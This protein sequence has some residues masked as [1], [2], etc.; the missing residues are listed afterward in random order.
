M[1]CFLIDPGGWVEVDDQA[2]APG[3]FCWNSEVGRR[4]LGVQT[5]WFQA[6]C[7][8][9]LVWDPIEVVEFSRKHTANIGDG[10]QEVRRILKGL[11]LK[12]EERKDSFVK[13]IRRAMEAKLGSDAEEALKVL[14]KQGIPRSAGQKA[15]K[16]A[17]EQGSFSVFTLIDVLTR[18]NQQLTYAGDRNEADQR[19]AKLF[20]L[21]S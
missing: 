5:F 17:E 19:S 3:F 12:R 11:V 7:A 14:N 20:D 8:N 18:M 16:L 2:F 13:V 15:L 21:V 4:S 1:F 10:L 9:H 6:V